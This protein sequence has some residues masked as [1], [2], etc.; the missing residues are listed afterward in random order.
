[1]SGR[2]GNPPIKD[3]SSNSGGLVKRISAGVFKKIAAL[4][5][6]ILGLLLILRII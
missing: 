2:R 1:M 6:V 5:V 3:V 4:A